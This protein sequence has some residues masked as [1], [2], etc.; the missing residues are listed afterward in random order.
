MQNK[1]FLLVLQKLDPVG[2][3]SILDDDILISCL[4]LHGLAHL[5]VNRTEDMDH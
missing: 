5:E 2:P 4:Y 3:T 1:P